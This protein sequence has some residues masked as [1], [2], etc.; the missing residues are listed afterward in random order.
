MTYDPSNGGG[1]LVSE[2][3][4]E[5]NRFEGTITQIDSSKAYLLRTNSFQSLEI[6]LRNTFLHDGNLPSTI[7]LHKGWNFVPIINIS[8]QSI[9]T[10]GIVAN[11]YFKNINPTSILGIN[12]FNNLAPIDRN[13]MVLYGKGYLVYLD[14]DDV[15]IP[16]K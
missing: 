10:Q 14:D 5:T 2:R 16:P 13:E 3:N 7:S 8:S 4:P 9:S 12:Q 6:G 15:L 11:E 1:W